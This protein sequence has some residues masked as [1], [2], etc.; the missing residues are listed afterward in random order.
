MRAEPNRVGTR[1]TPR[2]ES[3]VSRWTTSARA[4]RA[5]DALKGGQILRI[6]GN[7]AIAVVLEVRTAIEG[8][9][10]P[11]RAG[12]V[13][14][15]VVEGGVRLPLAVG[16]ITPERNQEYRKALVIT[17]NGIPFDW[18]ELDL[19]VLNGQVRALVIA[20]ESTGR[21]WVH[22]E[23]SAIPSPFST[24]PLGFP[25]S[26][27]V[28]IDSIAEMS[29]AAVARDNT[30]ELFRARRFYGGACQLANAALASRWI[31]VLDLDIAPVGGELSV[32]PPIPIDPGQHIAIMKSDATPI[33]LLRGLVLGVSS[34]EDTFTEVVTAGEA[35]WLADWSA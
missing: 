22:V 24:Q 30:R 26:P 20:S 33:R 14:Y 16:Y 10:T 1:P 7:A 29:S 12:V 6:P 27:V 18:Y 32:Y 11:A 23:H 31:F 8:E 3:F 34:T 19:A 25:T 17:A 35:Y 21:S 2:A 13:L 28:S 9:Q 4:K 15:G 5:T